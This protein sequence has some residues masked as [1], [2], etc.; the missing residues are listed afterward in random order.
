MN[1]HISIAA[2][3]LPPW[4]APRRICRRGGDEI[5]LPAFS[6]LFLHQ[7]DHFLTPVQTYV[8]VTTA[9]GSMSDRR[10]R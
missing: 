6:P 5:I 7:Q 9:T 8:S 10:P 3:D 4:P 2:A 1:E